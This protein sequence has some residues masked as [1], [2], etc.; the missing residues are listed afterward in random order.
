MAIELGD[1]GT[2][3]DWDE[4]SPK[5]KWEL[6]ARKQM[7]ALKRELQARG[8]TVSPV[9]YNRGGSAVMGEVSFYAHRHPGPGALDMTIGERFARN[10]QAIYV[11][12]HHS[13]LDGRAC[14]MYRFEQWPEH[15]GGE[16]SHRRMGPNHF[17]GFYDS[18]VDAIA[19]A[20]DEFNRS[21]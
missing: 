4:N 1:Y 8:F 7:R 10:T 11:Q 20:A 19:A 6:K 17:T 3:G 18:D 14:I 21:Y 15:L 9:H 12:A 2:R 5:R 13:L 16:R